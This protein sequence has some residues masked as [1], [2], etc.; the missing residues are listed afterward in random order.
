MNEQNFQLF[1][2]H[3]NKELVRRRFTCPF[4]G[5]YL[6]LSNCNRP[7]GLKCLVCKEDKTGWP[8]YQVIQLLP[9]IL[10]YVSVIELFSFVVIT[11]LLSNHA[12]AMFVLYGRKTIDQT[13]SP[14]KI[15]LVTFN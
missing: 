9:L 12:I 13:G 6:S 2:H 3:F 11:L 8:C 5:Q 14:G 4:T 7:F 15:S 1:Y 10:T